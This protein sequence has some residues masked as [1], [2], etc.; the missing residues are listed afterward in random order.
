MKALIGAAL[1]GAAIL[2]LVKYFLLPNVIVGA[3]P[4]QREWLRNAFLM[5]TGWV[6]AGIVAVAAVFALP[7]LAVTLWMLRRRT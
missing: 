7:I 4:A 3:T 6:L 1:T 5:H 2:T